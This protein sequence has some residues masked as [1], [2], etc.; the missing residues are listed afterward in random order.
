M[1][2]P[3]SY[4]LGWALLAKVSL[5]GPL[6]WSCETFLSVDTVA[7]IAILFTD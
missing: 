5:A 6:T 7:F 3:N 1:N 2:V 4:L